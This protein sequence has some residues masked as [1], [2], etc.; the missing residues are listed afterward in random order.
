MVF[1]EI[2]KRSR[3]EAI[4][5][6]FI[7]VAF[8]KVSLL[9][10]SSVFP[11]TAHAGFFSSISSIFGGT[12]EEFTAP[13]GHNSQTMP[14]L[15]APL[16]VNPSIG[17]GDV[18]IVDRSAIMPDLNAAGGIGPDEV[19][20]HQISL[21]V[22]KKGD[23]L[24]QIAKMF[25]VSVNT[26]IWGNDLSGG[27]ISEGQML[28]ILPISGVKHTVKAGDTVESIAK[29]YKSDA[30]EIRQFN[31]LALD[32]K[33]A[34]GDTVIVPDGEK[35]SI[36]TPS[37][38]GKTPSSY[39]APKNPL[40]LRSVSDGYW[41][42]PLPDGT[43]VRTQG[44]HGYN[45]V[46]IGVALGTPV[47]ASA[48][49]TVIVSKNSGWNGGYGNYVVIAHNN[50]AQ[51]LYAHLTTALVPVGTQVSRG[52]MIGKSGSS[53][54]STGPHLHLEYRGAVNPWASGPSRI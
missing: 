43:G 32:A 30:T 40:A 17:G 4:K 15:R 28:V 25:G 20:S 29:K 31:D 45:A 18:S 37:S 52:Q 10:L 3:I 27:V 51:T 2:S 42:K 22:V 41:G 6:V 46:D 7:A 1:A 54:N 13:A 35:G 11:A 53:G 33:L 9:L 21:Y 5:S 23:S 8:L 26:I 47:L 50:G 16:A 49:G 12:V 44:I 34:V 38:S 24:S 36:Q 14:L 19:S 39:G 48:D